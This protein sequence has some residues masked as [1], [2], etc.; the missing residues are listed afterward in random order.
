MKKA[1]KLFQSL[2]S[3]ANQLNIL[4]KTS[5]CLGNEHGRPPHV[6]RIPYQVFIYACA[7]CED[8]RR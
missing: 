8:H 2:D 3:I 6:R 5:S 7:N 1:V 4:S